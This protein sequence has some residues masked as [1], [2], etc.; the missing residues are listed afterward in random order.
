MI[1][2]NPMTGKEISKKNI[3]TFGLDDADNERIRAFAPPDCIVLNC[4]SYTDLIAFDGCLSFI[5]HAALKD[6]ELSILIDFYCKVYEYE[7]DRE[8]GGA[9]FL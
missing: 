6:N 3:L 2:I 1:A 4:D 5:N 7:N 8:R 9:Y